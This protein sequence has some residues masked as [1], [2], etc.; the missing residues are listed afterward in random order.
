MISLICETL[1]SSGFIRSASW[2]LT[3]H[4]KQIS[5]TSFS[6]HLQVNWYRQSVELGELVLT[7]SVELGE[8]VQVGA[9]FRWKIF[10]E[11]VQEAE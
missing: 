8:L 2:S 1:Q 5:Q 9:E 7:V 10:C 11:F 4:K 6:F 3:E